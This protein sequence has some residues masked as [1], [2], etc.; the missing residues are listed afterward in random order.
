MSRQRKAE[1]EFFAA[2]FLQWIQQHED[3]QAQQIEDIVDDPDMAIIS[4]G[5]K[6]AVE[7]SQVPSRYIIEQLHRRRP[8]PAYVENNVTGHMTIYP[9]E[10]HRWVHEVVKKKEVRAGRYR[11]RVGA[12]EVWLLLHSRSRTVNWP[13]SN[14]S[15]LRT[16]EVE[17]LL[18]RFGL[19]TNY[20]FDRV[21]YIYSDGSCVDLTARPMPISVS[22]MVDIGYPAFTSYMFSVGFQVPLNGFGSKIYNF[23][24]VAFTETTI[25]SPQDDWMRCRLP[26]VEYPVYE[27]RVAVDSNEAKWTIF[28]DGIPTILDIN[29]TSLQGRM[30]YAHTLIEWSVL[31]TRFEA[32]YDQPI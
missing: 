1:E 11:K 17:A 2:S 10:P 5:K 30:A 9:F 31:E 28:R 19:K 16:R 7:L 21:F 26:N 23:G 14:P 22:P 13:M 6:V 20:S 32:R 8:G 25:I 12:S 3:P 29:V 24:E 27:S 4:R 18:M 15:S